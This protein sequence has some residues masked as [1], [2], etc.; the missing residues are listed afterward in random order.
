MPCRAASPMSGLT[1][2]CLAEAMERLQ[3]HPALPRADGRVGLLYQPVLGSGAGARCDRHPAS[4]LYERNDLYPV[5][6]RWIR[7]A[8]SGCG[9]C[10]PA[11]SRPRF[12][13]T[14]W[15]RL[16]PPKPARPIRHVPVLLVPIFLGFVGGWRDPFHL[17]HLR[18]QL[19]SLGVQDD[20][21][22]GAFNPLDDSCEI[23][24]RENNDPRN[25]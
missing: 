11:R 5:Q 6:A 8:N 21:G 2:T 19:V 1:H 16:F 18:E 12:T 15:Q 3:A 13:F 25:E 14:P 24:L 17:L 20:L 23:H 7:T 9:A 4:D 22:P 10:P